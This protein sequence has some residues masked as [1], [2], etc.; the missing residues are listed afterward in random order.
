MCLSSLL[1]SRQ[2]SF[3]PSPFFLFFFF[4]L[5]SLGSRVQSSSSSIP[6]WPC[7]VKVVLI[8]L[9]DDAT[10]EIRAETEKDAGRERERERWFPRSEIWW[11]IR[12]DVIGS[13]ITVSGSRCRAV[14]CIFVRVLIIKHFWKDVYL[15]M[16]ISWK[17][18]FFF[19]LSLF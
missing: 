10:G 17:F 8:Y 18:L 3:S 13:W 19:S 15:A 16:W 11:W 9:R 1:S 14:Q 5:P 4:L 12:A 6:R 2:L 7:S